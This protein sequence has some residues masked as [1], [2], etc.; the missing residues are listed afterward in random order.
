MW[1]LSSSTRPEPILHALEGENLHHG[2]TREVSPRFVILNQSHT[3][4]ESLKLSLS[5]P[6]GKK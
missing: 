5:T 2:A 3:K 6:N 4:N 1:D